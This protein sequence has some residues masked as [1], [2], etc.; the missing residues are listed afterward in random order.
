MPTL[1][2][3][4]GR[5]TA[6]EFQFTDTVVIGRADD[7]DVRVFD[8]AASR[9]HAVVRREGDDYVALDQDSL[10]GLY[11]NGRRVERHVLRTG[12]EITVRNLTL[13]FVAEGATERPTVI[14]E[15][16]TIQSRLEPVD[17]RVG[18]D[19]EGLLGR[20]AA[21]YRFADVLNTPPRRLRAAIVAALE[22]AL[23]PC[24]AALV[25]PDG[26]VGT[27]S[28]SVVDHA[29]GQKEAVLVREPRVDM[30]QAS[31]LVAEKILC[32]MAAPLG[33]FGALYV[34][35]QE[36]EA[37]APADL[38]LLTA[39]ANAAT[40]CLRPADAPPPT[41]A[42]ADE[43]I[44]A[45]PAMKALREEIAQIAP[46]AATTLILGETGSGKELVA[47]ALHALSPRARGPFVAINCA[48]FVEN[49]LEAELFGHE[50]GAFTGADRARSG[51]FE[52]AHGGTIFLDEVGELAPGLQAK[53]LRVLESREFHRLGAAKPT[54][55]DV[56]IVAA[57]NRDLRGGEFRED[58]YYRLSVVSILCPPLRERAG[59]VRLL[60][61]AFLG[62]RTFTDKALAKL[63][64]Y[65]WPGNIRELKNVCE[66][67][68]VLAR[69]D[70]VD[71]DALPLEIRLG[72]AGATTD[73]G[74]VKTLREMEAEMVARALEATGGNR[75]QAAK[76][77]GIS[78][79][80]LKKKI[81]ELL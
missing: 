47:R 51:R 52:Q 79:P 45:S 73:R 4:R 34:H 40:P 18:G 41:A 53:L 19:D 21:V 38:E 58:L 31:S 43:M 74:A 7:C 48:A 65:D 46:T 70:T 32:A 68:A 59:D 27:F 71:V 75:T 17:A 1:R 2:V 29:R 69:G 63:E 30:P 54:R 36:G 50:K 57:S 37:F 81:D 76:L 26:N 49:L 14:S 66:R 10:N 56:R 22:E 16:L 78:Y 11:V 13:V 61:Q 42:P 15:R 62:E 3:A 44:G 35:R 28:H 12:D 8:E 55:V 24:S 20:L 39:L 23:A 80:T 9:H 33:G 64:A 60:A 77:L 6:P 25:L 5:S 67:C 72:H